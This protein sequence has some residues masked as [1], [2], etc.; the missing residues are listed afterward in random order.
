MGSLY[1]WPK[2]NGFAWGE[3]EIT[4]LIGVINPFIKFITGNR[5]PCTHCLFGSLWSFFERIILLPFRIKS[6][7]KSYGNISIY[8]TI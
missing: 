5:P 7:M 4:L 8:L 3:G 2:K 1:T 6:G